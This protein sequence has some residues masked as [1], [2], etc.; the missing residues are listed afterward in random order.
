MRVEI[1][2]PVY[3]GDTASD[4]A[5]RTS[6]S[7]KVVVDEARQVRIPFDYTLE[8]APHRSTPALT[9]TGAPDALVA[10]TPSTD[11]LDRSARRAIA[12]TPRARAGH[13]HRG[14]PPPGRPPRPTPTS[15]PASSPT[16]RE[17]LVAGA[18]A[19]AALWPGTGEKPN[20]YFNAGLAQTKADEFRIGIQMLSLRDDEQ[21]PDD[22]WDS[23]PETCYGVAR[24]RPA[25][26]RCLCLLRRAP[27]ESATT[28]LTR[29]TRPEDRRDPGSRRRTGAAAPDEAPE[30]P[31]APDSELPAEGEPTGP[32]F[33]E[34]DPERPE[35]GYRPCRE[36]ELTPSRRKEPDHA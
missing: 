36:P 18:L 20:P 31:P 21:Y 10:T 24:R 9:A 6:R 33:T 3:D 7:F 23:W 22:L 8:R 4:D 28:R 32:G 5:A 13:A 11:P 34:P 19:Q 2:D 16:A 30:P 35:R 17:V 26:H 12:S 15:S 25:H 14:L 29:T 1:A 27:G